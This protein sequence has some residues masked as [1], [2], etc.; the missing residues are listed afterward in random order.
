MSFFRSLLGLAK[1]HPLPFVLFVVAVV[2]VLGGIVWKLIS[3]IGKVPVVGGAVAKGAAAVAG[4][5]GSA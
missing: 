1:A 2:L 3:L 5:T 4:A